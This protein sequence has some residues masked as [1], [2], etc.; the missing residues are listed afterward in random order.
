MT[1]PH[2]I[3]IHHDGM[4]PFHATN[5]RDVAAQIERIRSMHV[6]NRGWG[7]IGYHYVVDRS[8]RS[9]S[10]RPIR[11]QGAHV[12]YQNP[13]NIGVLCLGNFEEQ[14]PSRQ[15]LSGLHVLLVA[16]SARYR[17]PERNILTHQEWSTAN[18][19]CPGRNLQSRIDAMR[20]SGTLV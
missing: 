13:G 1:T 3:T 20:R 14:S 9:W 10:A 7:D 16:L 5:A 12:Q 6:G 4:T 2:H 18:T 19:L 11:Y 17:I 8:G 15:Q